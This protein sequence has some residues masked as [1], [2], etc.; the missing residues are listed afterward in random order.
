MAVTSESRY[1]LI[2]G[3]EEGPGTTGSHSPVLDPASNQPFAEVAV[4]GADDARRAL[5]SADKAFRE[6][7][8]AGGDGSQ[9]TKALL[10]LAQ[11]LEAEV[12]RFAA[13]ETRN[14][15]KTLREAKGDI[16]FTV[17]TLEYVA[18]LADKIEGECIPVP[19]GRLDYTLREPL[20][21]TVHIAPWNFPLVLAIRSVAPALAAG[22]SVVLK[23]ASLTPLTALAFA[24]LAR[25]A[26]IPPGILNVVVGSGREVGE[27][28]LTDPRT[29]AISFTG[30]VEVGQ[31]VAELAGARHVPVTLE[32]GGK[33]PVVVFPDADLDRAA[34]G[35]VWG[36][37]DNAG[38]MCWAGSRLLV[39][40]SIQES[41]VGKVRALA[42][43]LKVG[44]G[45]EA[46]IEMGPLVS[47]DQLERV[48]GFVEEARRDGGRI[49]TGG[50]R[51]TDPA[52]AAGNFL[53]PTIVEGLG[54]E[55]RILREEIFGP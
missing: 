6:S 49:V 47:P 54:P 24:R 22:N 30:S 28:L 25:G 33:G 3:G 29:R 2:I 52:R 20:G 15:G 12:D 37:Y 10:R 5:E 38:Q 13:L 55:H 16:Q 21:P 31:R 4:G 27:T 34:K 43:K 32:L 8:W 40:Q 19:G 17:R 23:P 9:R 51:L 41:F 36:I 53:A 18:G 35:V 48:T 45:L 46:G 1:G 39:H 26:G 11:A 7:N 44:P 50:T 14:V 42:E